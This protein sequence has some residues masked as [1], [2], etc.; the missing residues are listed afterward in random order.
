MLL[1]ALLNIDVRT[2]IQKIIRHMEAGVFQCVPNG[3]IALKGF[4]M[5]WAKGL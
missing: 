2:L 5:T 3:A 1:G 4:F